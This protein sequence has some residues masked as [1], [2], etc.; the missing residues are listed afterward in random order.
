MMLDKLDSTDALIIVALEKELPRNLLPN[1]NIVYSGVGKVNAAFSVVNSY[2]TF[3][4][5]VII[6]YGTAGSLNENLNGLI[7]INSFK[8]RD[9]D[10]RPLGFEIG[11][12]P[13]DKINTITCDY[14]G[15]SC[16]TGDDFVTDKPKLETDIVDMESYSIAKFCLINNITFFCYKYISDNA[17]KDAPIDWELNIQKGAKLFVKSLNNLI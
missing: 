17:N 12:T 15:Y 6:N 1:W 2:N 10:V 9:M 11:E 5:K 3:K 4:P 8:Q 14:E 13:Y 16:G 7:P